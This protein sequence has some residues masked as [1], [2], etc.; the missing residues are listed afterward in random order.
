MMFAGIGL[1]GTLTAAIASLF[2]RES[3]EIEEDKEQIQIIKLLTE[4]NQKLDNLMINK[5]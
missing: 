2:V 5:K 1:F 3:F 4:I